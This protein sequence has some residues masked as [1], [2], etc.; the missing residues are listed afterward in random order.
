M[1]GDGCSQYPRLQ[2]KCLGR[3]LGG[4]V[5][6]SGS[7][8]K[9]GPAGHRLL[10]F[11]SGEW[12][13]LAPRAPQPRRRVGRRGQ[14]GAGQTAPCLGGLPAGRVV[15]VSSQSPILLEPRMG[16]SPPKAFSYFSSSFFLPICIPLA[17]NQERR[18]E[19]T[20]QVEFKA[21]GLC[22]PGL[23]SSLKLCFKT[24]W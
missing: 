20:R 19:I 1:L 9:E 7:S 14:A 12:R 22:A 10:P 6:G 5:G 17:V 4:C 24:T 21:C 11:G 23:S 13:E 2:C 16:H 15:G 3:A 8:Q 18:P